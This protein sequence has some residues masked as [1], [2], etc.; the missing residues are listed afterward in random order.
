[1]DRQK[2]VESA[3]QK[4][5]ELTLGNN[6]Y[7]RWLEAFFEKEYRDDV[8]ARDVT[9]QA[10]LTENKPRKAFLKAKQSGIIAGVKEVSWFLRKYNLIVKV[11]MKDGEKVSG[12]ETVLEIQGTQKDIL[13]TERIA[14]NVLQRMSGIATE[15]KRLADMLKGYGTRIAATRKTPLRYLDKKAVFLGGGLTHRFG[16][17]DA[18]LIKDNHLET[19]KSEGTGDYI[20]TAITNASAF[21]EEVEFIEIEVTTHEEAIRAAKKFKASQL[22]TPCVVMLDNMTPTAIAE[23]I[24]TLRENNLYDHVLL[25]ASGKITPENIQEY[26]RTGIDIVSLGYLTHSTK[27]LDLSLEMTL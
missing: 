9:S 13:A 24:E 1:M 18:I 8:G 10:V 6:D 11:C 27:V 14:L 25:E 21:A 23:T 12:G 4:G 16:L 20:E 7:F 5:K 26:A 2:L 19:L 17:W 15:T 3:Y 22:K